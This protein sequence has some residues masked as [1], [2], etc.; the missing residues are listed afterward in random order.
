MVRDRTRGYIVVRPFIDRVVR[1][2]VIR[3][4][5]SST[6][7]CHQTC[8][9]SGRTVVVLD[10][11]HRCDLKLKGVGAALSRSKTR[12]KT[13]QRPRGRTEGRA[14]ARVVGSVR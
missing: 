14:D 5:Y 6:T 13:R 4:T 11:H 12:S 9:Y 2:L 3:G 8:S 10:G 7:K 1:T